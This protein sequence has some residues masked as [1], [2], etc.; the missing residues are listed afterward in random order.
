MNNIMYVYILSILIV[1]LVGEFIIGTN[2]TKKA[3]LNQEKM[4]QECEYIYKDIKGVVKNQGSW[5]GT[6]KTWIQVMEN[7]NIIL[8]NDKDFYESFNIS[9]E[10][11]VVKRTVKN[12]I[13][14]EILRV[15]YKIDYNVS[16]QF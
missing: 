3:L 7:A 5:R 13:T 14:G 10:V 15:D 12:K 9:E 1:L 11:P 2:M 8:I 16:N 4:E 6:Y